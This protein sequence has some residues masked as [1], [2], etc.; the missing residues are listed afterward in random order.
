MTMRRKTIVLAVCLGC[1]TA[2][3]L[4][5]GMLLVLQGLF[6]SR[7]M[8][9]AGLI[10]LA[11]GFLASMALSSFSRE[12]RRLPLVADGRAGTPDLLLLTDQARFEIDS[13]PNPEDLK[14]RRLPAILLLYCAL[15]SGCVSFPN[16]SI[17]DDQERTTYYDLLGVMEDHA[18]RFPER[19]AEL[20]AAYVGKP[21]Q[22]VREK[23]K[24]QHFDWH[25]YRPAMALIYDLV[26][27][28]PSKGI[29]WCEIHP[30]LTRDES[31]FVRYDDGIVTQIAVGWSD[32]GTRHRQA[33]RMLEAQGDAMIEKQM[34]EMFSAMG[35]DPATFHRSE[36][37]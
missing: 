3:F 12:A 11:L 4:G 5:Y 2:Y 6:M 17:T 28:A 7:T 33:M 19:T 21:V 14:V 8:F 26:T 25:L 1:A 24:K 13:H 31:I 34:R 15:G 18:A 16:V 23:L 36:E 32:D 10:H 35:C 22:E 9:I 37:R 27:L 20:R 30:I 29:A